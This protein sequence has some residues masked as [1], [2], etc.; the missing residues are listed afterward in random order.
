MINWQLLP[1]ERFM[2]YS[3]VGLRVIDDFSGAGPVGAIE[4]LLDVQDTNGDWHTMDVDAVRTAGDVIAYPGLGRT[5]YVGVQPM[6]RY[7]VRLEADFYRP[8]YLINL[9]AV[10]FDV[11]PYDDQNPPAVI[12]THPQTVFM[13]PAT[14]YQYPRHV[15]VVRG[16][17]EDNNGDPVANVEVTEGPRERVLTDERGT[18]SLPLRWP[19]LNAA[20][21]IDALDH[22][23]GLSGQLN[24]NLPGDLTGG[25]TI[26]I[27]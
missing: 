26:I 23:T 15:R 9:D 22:R 20:V 3:P 6:M 25:H 2:L 17:V 24:I 4:A 10:E 16:R 14:Q 12:P 5:A 27:T 18:F 7:R 13:L 19:A 11:H 21:Q 1:D 8:D